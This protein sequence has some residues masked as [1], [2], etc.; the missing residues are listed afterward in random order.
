MFRRSSS[1]RLILMLAVGALVLAPGA[2]RAGPVSAATPASASIQ[3]LRDQAAALA[4]DRAERD[5][6]SAT[7]WTE[8]RVTVSRQRDARWAFGTVVLTAPQV[9]GAQPRDWLFLAELREGRWQV[10]LD[11]QDAFATISARS[12]LLTTAE[13]RIFAT[14]G[15]RAGTLAN[16][17]Y[18]TGMRLP[19]AIGQSWI[20]RGGPHAY[21]AGSGPWSSVDL[22]GGDERV[23][24]ARAGVAYTTCTGLI[25]VFHDRGYST[26]YYHLINHIW[27]DGTNLAEGAFLG[28]T[29]T[30]VRCG[31]AASSRHVHFSLMQNDAFVAITRHPIGKWIFMNGGSQY[32]GYALHGSTRADRYETLYNYGP[33]GLTQGIVDSNGG[34]TVNKRSGPGT[35]HS[36]VG[37]LADGVTVSIACSANGTTHTGR[38]GTTSLWHRL[39]DGTWA[40]DAYIYTGLDTPVNGWC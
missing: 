25:R 32:G 21:D 18:R 1:Y 30:E 34:G 28:Y 20:L 8:S 2:V 39:T 12:P 22:Y 4:H 26:R 37:S 11:G 6:G 29:G 17:D 9:D 27:V 19:W 7:D 40:S 13:K 36:I 3:A 38:W 35:G 14:H 5:A 15:A 33:L 10:G 23:L 24:A 31:G 16:G